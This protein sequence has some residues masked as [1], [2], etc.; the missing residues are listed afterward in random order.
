MQ[1]VHVEFL[2]ILS[3]I[4]L[5]VVLTPFTKVEESFNVQ[6]TYDLLYKAWNNVSSFDHVEFPGVVPRT[7]IGPLILSVLSM[8][9]KVVLNLLPWTMLHVVRAVL[10]GLVAIS[11][12][13]VR[14]SLASRYCEQTGRV[15]SA[16]V[17]VQFHTLYYASRPL[18][19]VFALVLTNLALAEQLRERACASEYRA[20]MLVSV[21]CA[22]FRSELC[23][24]LFT[25]FVV[26]YAAGSVSI[27][28]TIR[29]AL[30]AAMAG[31]LASIC[32]DWHFWQRASY[33]ELE[34]FYFNV[35]LNKSSAWGTE[36]FLWYFYNALP[37]A[38]G[39]CFVVGL[40]G[41]WSGDDKMRR[42]VAAALM[43]VG[44]YSNLPHKELRFIL[45]VLPVLN[46]AAAVAIQT[47]F[48]RVRQNTRAA[49]R[50][51]HDD[52]RK[53]GC[54]RGDVLRAAVFGAFVVATLVACM[55]QTVI[56]SAASRWNYPAGHALMRLH[57]VEK[58]VCAEAGGL[59]R[60]EGYVHIDVD[61]AMGGIS[62]FVQES[63]EREKSCWTWRYSKREDVG[64]MRVA[65]EFSHLVWEREAVDGFCVIHVEHK[66]AGVDWRGG[67][68]RRRAHTFVHRNVNVST[69]G[70]VGVGGREMAT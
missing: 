57:E 54:K 38:L 55:A 50:K 1:I 48:R 40:M 44:L 58:R 34:V 60:M 3:V 56:S 5:H 69:A 49:A 16:I 24:Y 11:L 4:L 30:G 46:A 13:Q 7:F 35:V 51:K 64:G 8:G 20:I 52:R 70:C 17:I 41:V 45:Y 42:L 6:A 22:L 63:Y 28:G 36:P 61:S 33:P 31:A 27:V 66:F 39:G 25:T 18:P 62:Q 67:A 10:G 21:A 43:F 19:N 65:E 14:K 29:N 32:V 59:E 2:L 37:R 53:T 26:N 9:P 47:E 23:L 12:L 68:I 15:F